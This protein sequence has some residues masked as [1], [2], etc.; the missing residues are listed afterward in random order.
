MNRKLFTYSA[1]RAQRVPT[2]V[3]KRVG[4]PAFLLA[5]YGTVRWVMSF[6]SALTLWTASAHVALAQTSGGIA[7]GVQQAS[8]APRRAIEP[9]DAPTNIA[10]L[11]RAA[12][13]PG[14]RDDV[15]R[16]PRTQSCV[17]MA[18]TGLPVL[19]AGLN[20]QVVSIPIPGSGRQT[21]VTTI[22]KPDGN[23]PF[24]MV[25]FNHGKERGDPRAQ[26]RS[27]PLPFAREFVRRGYVVVAPNRQ[28]FAQSGGTYVDHGC[29]V[30]DNGLAQ[31]Q[32]VAATIAYMST[33]P[34][35]DARHIVVAGASHGGLT[36]IAYGQQP[37]RGVHGLLNFAGGLRQDACNGWQH[38]LTHAFAT[39]GGKAR[40]PSLW[41]YG[42]NDALWSPQLVAQMY[43]AYVA[44]GAH[45]ELV[46]FGFYKDNAHRIVGDRDGVAL[47]WPPTQQFLARIGMPTAVRYRV[48]DAPAAQPTGYASIDAIDAV[49]Y[50][51]GSGREGYATFLKQYPS[52]AFAVSDS[53]AWSWAEGG[54]NPVSVA[55]DNCQKH[56][57]DPCQLYA[58]D[59]A[60]VWA[61][62]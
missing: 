34:Y 45:A 17:A 8:R 60:V 12:A 40:L 32:D 11:R 58:V 48:E 53:G 14:I 7:P 27:R 42:E 54:D 52:R 2:S 22:F 43:S 13:A 56:S 3:V 36:T 35:I 5:R 19:P 30:A 46:D 33:Q 18:N 55:L 21:L 16:P 23:G 20:E 39:Y 57:R 6:A 37:Q 62:R 31:A 38:N 26:P 28:G 29:D 25:V 1:T 51:N 10:A 15:S 4:W 47:W 59:N 49:P 44:G 41:F 50:L 24:Q 9:I 61:G